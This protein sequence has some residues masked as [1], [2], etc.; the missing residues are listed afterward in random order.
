M[1]KRFVLV[2]LVLVAAVCSGCK[3]AKDPVA[4]AEEPAANVET[5]TAPVTDSKAAE[6]AA[7]ARAVAAEQAAKLAADEKAKAEQKAQMAIARAAVADKAAQEALMTAEAVTE[8]KVKVESSLRWFRFWAFSLSFAFV[9]WL[10]AT[11]RALRSW[12]QIQVDKAMAYIARCWKWLGEPV[13]IATVVTEPVSPAAQP[14]D[15]DDE[16]ADDVVA[17]TDAPAQQTV[18]GMTGAEAAARC[19]ERA[20]RKV[21]GATKPLPKQ[22]GLGDLAAIGGD[23]Q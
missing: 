7:L 3:V 13:V 6:K 16:F 20:N 2:S 11:R 22:L 14:A 18:M 17:G 9:L 4:V 5:K 19:A 8:A 15:Q 1:F 10:I 12:Y 21:R 23:Q